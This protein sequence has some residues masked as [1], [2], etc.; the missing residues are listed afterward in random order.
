[1]G[2]V[3]AKEQGYVL[4]ID[5]ASNAAGV[6]LWQTGRLIA[7]T[8]LKSRKA[9]DPLSV[10]LQCQVPQLTTFLN[11]NV[12]GDGCV[13][14]IIFE[15][16][17]ARIVMVTVGAFLMSPRIAVKLHQRHTF[18]ESRQWKKFAAD[19]GATGPFKDIKG[20]RALRE[21]GFPVDDHGIDSDD[22]ADSI[23][24][25]LTWRER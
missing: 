5:Q 25:Y 7:H 23:L 13:T 1:M 4:S 11:Q 3:L 20:L 15:G 12:P 8:V 14:K 16:V 21:I 19:R 6:S 24:I 22:V 2:E 18:V 17:K 9:A 10:R